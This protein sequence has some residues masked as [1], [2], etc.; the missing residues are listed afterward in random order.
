MNVLSQKEYKLKIFNKKNLELLDDELNLKILRELVAGN[1]I[2]INKNQLSKLMGR[3]RQTIQSRLDALF[4]YKIINPPI[5]PF[6]GLFLEYPLLIIAYSDLPIYEDSG[7]NMTKNWI[8]HDNHIFGAFRIREGVFNT[9]LLE[10]HQSVSD[11]YAWRE[12]L[13]DQKIPSRK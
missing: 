11:Y 2:Q 9:L 7:S 3:H 4:K 10:F 1:G 5:C 6:L 8:L 12:S 13:V